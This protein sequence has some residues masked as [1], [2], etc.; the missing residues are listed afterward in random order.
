MIAHC[1]LGSGSG[2]RRAAGAFSAR[3]P[4]LG[5]DDDGMRQ[6]SGWRTRKGKWS[7]AS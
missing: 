5:G 3:L 2:I 4:F 7:G 6:R 1:E